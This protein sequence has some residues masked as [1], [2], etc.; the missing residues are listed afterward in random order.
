M[1]NKQ[2][3]II[4]FLQIALASNLF[5]QDSTL[6]KKSASGFVFSFGTEMNNL[7][8][9]NPVGEE[10]FTPKPGILIGAG[11]L[12]SVKRIGLQFS[13]AYNR[14]SVDHFHEGL[15][16]PS[17]IS[18]TTSANTTSR[19]ETNIKL[20][21][22]AFGFDALLPLKQVKFIVGFNVV[23]QNA[24]KT[25]RSIYYGNGTIENSN[26]KQ[27]QINYAGKLSLGYSLAISPRSLIL[28][29]PYFKYYLHEFLIPE[30]NVYNYGLKIH[31]IIGG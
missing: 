17:D 1:T 23:S 6:T 24:G 7:K 19:M 25:S 3:I 4:T 14:K 10:S 20:N 2:F 22:Y 9:G 29:E 8:T 15:V 30:S 16:F 12:V 28:F 26:P 21:E 18:Q 31:Y 13:V 11:Y 27:N 5:C